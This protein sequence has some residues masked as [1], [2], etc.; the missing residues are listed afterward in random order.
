M[1]WAE[2]GA[3]GTIVL[4]EIDGQPRQGPSYGIWQLGPARLAIQS[5][6]GGGVGDPLE[7]EVER[8]VRDVR[9]GVVSPDVAKDVYGVVMRAD[10]KAAQVAA[11][12]RR[13][14]ELVK[15]SGSAPAEAVP[16]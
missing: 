8:V 5:P 14:Q 1:C 3:I 10:G 9:D 13:R 6:G 11:T 4:T 15:S 16:A 7:R 12:A 2:S